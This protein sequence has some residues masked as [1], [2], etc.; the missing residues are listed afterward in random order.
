MG[1]KSNKVVWWTTFVFYKVRQSQIG[2]Y[3]LFTDWNDLQNEILYSHENAPKF[4]TGKYIKVEN[5]D[6]EVSV[7]IQDDQDL[8][9]RQQKSKYAVQYWKHLPSKAAD[10]KDELYVFTGFI[11]ILN[12]LK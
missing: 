7:S 12:I 6:A 9:Y 2:F 5:T 4:Q 10:L 1:V 8:S 3:I 11:L